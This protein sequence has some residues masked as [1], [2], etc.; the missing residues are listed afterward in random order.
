[1]SDES[2]CGACSFESGKC[3]WKDTS[4]GNWAWNR[5]TADTVTDVN[6][7]QGDHTSGSKQGKLIFNFLFLNVRFNYCSN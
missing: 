7:P 4:S 6:G 2:E 1:M 5:E 3:G